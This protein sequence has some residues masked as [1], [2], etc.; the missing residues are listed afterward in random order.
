MAAE[1]ALKLG[2]TQSSIYMLCAQL[3]ASGLSDGTRD[4][5]L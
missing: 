2:E 4:F 1:P 5:F 3:A